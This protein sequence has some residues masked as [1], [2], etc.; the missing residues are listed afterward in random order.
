MVTGT[1]VSGWVSPVRSGAVPALLATILALLAS[2]PGLTQTAAAP[3]SES[4][5]ASSADLQEIVVTAQRRSERLQDVPVAVTALSESSLQAAGVGSTQD[6]P[7]VTPGL[8]FNS[9]GGYAQPRIRGIGTTG[10]A[11]SIENPVALYVDGVYYAHQVGSIFALNNIEQVE[12]DKG[13]QGTLFGRNATGGLIQ[14]T[15]DKPTQELQGNASVSYGNYNTYATADYIAGGI[16]K[17]LAADL[18]VYYQDQVDGYGT[19]IAT[20]QQINRDASFSF[21]SKW[22]LTPTSA[23]EVMLIADYSGDNGAYAQAPAPGTTPL[24]GGSN[25][26]PQNV[27]VPTPY[28]NLDREGGVSLHIRQ[29]FDSMQFVST[30]AYRKDNDF[31]LFPNATANIAAL[32]LVTLPD[33]FKQ[34]SQEFQLSSADHN[35]FRWTTGV[36]LFYAEGGWQPLSLT[37]G[38]ALSTIAPLT[39]IQIPDTQTTRSAAAY[40]QGTQKLSE[41]TNLTLGVRYTVD[42]RQWQGSEIFTAPFPIPTVEDSAN[43]TFKKPTWRIALDQK[44][45]DSVMGYV[46]YNRGFKSG[47]FNDSVVPA[48][49]YKPETVDA[50]ELGLKTEFF[51]RRL[52]WN[53]AAFY[54]NYKDIQVSRYQFGNLVIYNGAAA[55]LYGLDMDLQANLLRDFTLTTGLS[56]VH[57]RFT[58]FPDASITTPQPGGGTIFGTGSATGNRLTNTPD[59]TAD[60]AADYTIPTSIGKIGLNATYYHNSGWY[61]SVDMRLRQPAY[62]VVNTSVSLTSAGDVWRATLWAKNLSNETYAVYLAAQANGDSIQYAPPRT[63]GITLQYKF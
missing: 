57:D 59:W 7:M 54:Y 60:V 8:V 45:S 29:D 22:V 23:T 27:N 26:E 50:Y 43:A 3:T 40:A 4:P 31:I 35:D 38:G 16:T 18:S 20:G 42:K 49:P 17:D 32:T 11:P 25:L 2:Q 1:C 24:G 62:D 5:T 55:R 53:T 6:L 61:G 21:R 15:T 10:D 46:S 36:F 37:S 48:A 39:E 47:G 19:N 14:V 33:S 30:T 34:Y 44:L 9:V 28:K 52:R 41:T 56:Y 13:P 51:E 58:S 12:V 63:Y